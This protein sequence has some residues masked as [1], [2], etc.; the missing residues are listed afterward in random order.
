MSWLVVIGLCVVWTFTMAWVEHRGYM[1]G[2]SEGRAQGFDEGAAAVL[3]QAM[4]NMEKYGAVP[5]GTPIEPKA[6]SPRT[7]AA[8]LSTI[9]GYQSAVLHPVSCLCTG[10]RVM[11]HRSDCMCEICQDYRKGSGN[12]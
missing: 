3:N 9:R 11:H 5:A 4:S 8:A 7:Q 2:V 12:C 10:C 6:V 1:K